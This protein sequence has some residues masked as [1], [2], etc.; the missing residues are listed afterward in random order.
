MVNKQPPR[1]DT[2]SLQIKSQQ[3]KFGQEVARMQQYTSNEDKKKKEQFFVAIGNANAFL[4]QVAKT[5]TGLSRSDLSQLA[6][7]LSSFF[8]AYSQIIFLPEELN[9]ADMQA[10]DREED[11]RQQIYPYMRAIS[12]QFFEKNSEPCLVYC[13]SHLAKKGSAEAYLDTASLQNEMLSNITKTY[14]AVQS[15]KNKTSHILSKSKK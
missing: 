7:R 6:Q 2:L 5:N 13:L 4:T 15:T 11:L 9:S 14:I 8:V 1:S 3:A 12:P 10:L